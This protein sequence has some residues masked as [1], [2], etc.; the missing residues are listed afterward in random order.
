MRRRWLGVALNFLFAHSI[1]SPHQPLL[2][3]S[4]SLQISGAQVQ[5]GAVGTEEIDGILHATKVLFLLF[6][7]LFFAS[8]VNLHNPEEEKVAQPCPL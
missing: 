3:A 7:L 5:A 6:N 8:S 4:V 2:K 1:V